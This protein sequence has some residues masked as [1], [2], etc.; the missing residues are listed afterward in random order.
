M[1]QI[2]K[3]NTI[4]ALESLLAFRLVMDLSFEEEKKLLECE[5]FRLM[6][7]KENVPNINS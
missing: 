4:V 5:H 2:L 3:S 6:L 1:G 7:A